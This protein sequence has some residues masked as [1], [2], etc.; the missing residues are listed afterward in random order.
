MHLEELGVEFEPLPEPS[1]IQYLRSLPQESEELA[2]CGLVGFAP[3]G[4][5]FDNLNDCVFGTMLGTRGIYYKDTPRAHLE[6]L[7]QFGCAPKAESLSLEGNDKECFVI[8]GIDISARGR[9]LDILPQ[10]RLGAACEHHPPPS[11]PHHI[12]TIPACTAPAP[13][14]P[15]PSFH[16]PLS[17]VPQLDRRSHTSR[18]GRGRV[19]APPLAASPALHPPE[20]AS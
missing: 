2:T 13:T 8:L 5:F 12:Q 20:A 16:L 15:R 1:L 10:A 11:P 18:R 6:Y 7:V 17:S 19:R 4:T 9:M 3:A 14:P